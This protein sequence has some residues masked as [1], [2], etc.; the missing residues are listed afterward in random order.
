MAEIGGR[1][2]A[3]LSPNPPGGNQLK[4]IW[5]FATRKLLAVPSVGWLIADKGGA[6]A[7]SLMSLT[8]PLKAARGVKAVRLFGHLDN[9]ARGARRCRA[10]NSAN[11]PSCPQARLPQSVRA[12]AAHPRRKRG[13]GNGR[14]GRAP[15]RCGLHED[16]PCVADRANSPRDPQRAPSIYGRTSGRVCFAP[17]I[18]CAFAPT[19]A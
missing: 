13:H 16:T 2:W 1:S 4:G 11:L 14:Q 10:I 9:L 6:R 3:I 19:S 5:N 17:P 15:P 12:A 8:Q 18:F 7:S